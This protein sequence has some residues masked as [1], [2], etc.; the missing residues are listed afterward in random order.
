MGMENY[1]NI[2]DN[3]LDAAKYNDIEN[4]DQYAAKRFDSRL[5]NIMS[6]RKKAQKEYKSEKKFLN[7][8]D[9][10][11]LKDYTKKLRAYLSALHDYAVIY[12]NDNPVITNPDTS[13]EVVSETQ[14][15]LNESKSEF[16]KAK[17]DW[18]NSYNSIANQ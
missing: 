3:L 2:E 9:K 11:A 12:Q 13:Q 18:V 7:S 1:Q 8:Q 16:D 6:L 14:N 5:K 15:E 4:P 17:N 10:A